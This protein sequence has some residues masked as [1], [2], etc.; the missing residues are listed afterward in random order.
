MPNYLVYEAKRCRPNESARSP[1][2]SRHCNR[3]WCAMPTPVSPDYYKLTQAYQ[4]I[5][6]ILDKDE[7]KTIEDL[8]ERIKEAQEQVNI[9]KD[10]RSK[11]KDTKAATIEAVEQ[12]IMDKINQATEQISK[13]QA[14][15]KAKKDAARKVLQ[16]AVAAA[17]PYTGD[18]E[19][20]R[21]ALQ[22]AE[23][24][25]VP[26]KELNDAREK[27]TVMISFT[28]NLSTGAKDL[29]KAAK[30]KATGIH[31]KK[32]EEVITEVKQDAVATL[33][34]T[35]IELWMQALTKVTATNV[36]TDDLD[37]ALEEAKA[38][39]MDEAMWKPFKKKNDEAKKAQVHRHAPPPRPPPCPAPA[40][41][42]SPPM[43]R[44][45]MRSCGRIFVWG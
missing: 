27:L 19:G 42:P 34:K 38:I 24:A 22:E 10:W 15:A 9:Q 16:T 37:K 7:E 13:L 1:L 30:G 26:D 2:W 3:S 21:E 39:G 11:Q 14:E 23:D 31:I 4:N 29:N 20:L 28:F 32:L 44:W 41:I 8:E 35:E 5:Q 36:A 6:A 17:A 33:K 25:G 40:R 43:A 18:Q 12:D 45:G